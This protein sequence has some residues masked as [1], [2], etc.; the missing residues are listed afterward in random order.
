MI[1]AR[2]GNYGLAGFHV[3]LQYVSANAEFLIT[4]ATK[5]STTSSVCGITRALYLGGDNE[6][7]AAGTGG[8]ETG[9]AATVWMTT[10]DF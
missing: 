5:R 3:R 8:M 7:D 4:F 1:C 10:K 9:A 6:V 2:N